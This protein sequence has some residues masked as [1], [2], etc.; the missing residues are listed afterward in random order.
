MLRRIARPGVIVDLGCGDGQLIHAMGAHGLLRDTTYAVDLS[1]ERVARAVE[2]APGVEG[3]VADA[4]SVPL[5]G[6]VADGIVCNVVIEHVRD[7][8]ALV[9]EVARLLR[10]GGW[11]YI[12]SCLA[13]R[14]AWWIYRNTRGERVLDPTHVR[15]Y[16]SE[17]AFREVLTHPDLLIAEL[18]SRPQRFPLLDLA[19]R[20]TVN[21]VAADF[22]LRHPLALPARRVP[23][24]VPGYRLL[25]AYGAH[26]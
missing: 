12:S 1:P 20:A 11:W 22:Y 4:G 17:E 5:P 3:I 16:K 13:G 26:R 19:L 8:R 7:D 2:M 24:R 21:S 23:I 6:N 25:E 9:S 18:A 15:E 10:P 14:R